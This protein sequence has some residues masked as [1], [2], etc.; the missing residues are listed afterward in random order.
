METYGNEIIKSTLS[1]MLIKIKSQVKVIGKM[2][3][4]YHEKMMI[5]P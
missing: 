3:N 5:V 2:I 1:V 4:K